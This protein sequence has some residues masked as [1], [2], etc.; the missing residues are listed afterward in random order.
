GLSSPHAQTIFASLARPLRVPPLRRERWELPDGDFLD[1]DVLD[2]PPGASTEVPWLLVLHGLEGSSQAGYVASILRGAHERGWGAL[3]L[4][5][6]SCGGEP[7]RLPRFY[8]SGET[9]DVKEAIARLRERTGGPILGVGFSLGGNVLLRLLE[10][11]GGGAPLHAAAAVSV[12]FDLA[13]CARTLDGGGGLVS[14]YRA[15]FLR[16]LRRKAL[17]KA[18]C[19]PGSLDPEAVRRA[20]GIVDF[21]DAV[22]APL[23]GYASAGAYYEAC[24]SGPALGAIRRP[25]LCLSAADDPL[26]PASC[27][28]RPRPGPVT[29]EVTPSGGHVGFVAGSIARPTFWAEERVLRFLEAAAASAAPPRVA[30][31]G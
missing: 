29:V 20:K 19:H 2:P 10:E 24:S 6:R 31:E 21:D 15:V 25:T 17:E 26:V 9:G 7:N 12:P 22:T 1:V 16:S 23:H 30:P 14:I 11:E 5:F 4:N 8:H 13:L 18:R 3:A 28:P 27:L